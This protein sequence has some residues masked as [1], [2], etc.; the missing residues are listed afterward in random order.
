VGILKIEVIWYVT[1]CQVIVADVKK[2]VPLETSV[3][4]YQSTRCDMWGGLDLQRLRCEKLNLCVCVCVC[5]CYF[6]I[7]DVPVVILIVWHVANPQMA[8]TCTYFHLHEISVSE[9]WCQLSDG[10]DVYML[11]IVRH[12]YSN[13]NVTHFSFRHQFHFNSGAANWHNTHAVYQMPLV[14]RLLRMSK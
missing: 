7:Y 6:L 4:T 1:R 5:V 2:G 12:Q 9:R 3:I 10:F 13:N 14:E 8:R 11:T